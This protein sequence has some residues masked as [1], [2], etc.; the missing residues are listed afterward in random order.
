MKVVR[1][2]RDIERLRQL[3][4]YL[5]EGAA[6]QCTFR[7]HAVV[8]REARPRRRTCPSISSR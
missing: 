2:D 5:G 7:D 6:A 3:V 4:P 8:I 1:E